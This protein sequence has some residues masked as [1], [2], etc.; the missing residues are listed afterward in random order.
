M[1]AAAGSRGYCI[2]CNKIFSREENHKCSQK[3]SKGFQ[4]PACDTEHAKQNCGFC[5]REFFGNICYKNHQ[6]PNS[7]DKKLSVSQG[8]RVFTICNKT[9]RVKEGKHE[10]GKTFCKIC[11]ES[12][13]TSHFCYV[14]P[15]IE[16]S[17]NSKS[18]FFLCF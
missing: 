1:V 16:P 10:C 2:T 3:C 13:P 8:I 7:F 17:K 9:V 11:K 14:Q 15:P 5:S 12:L 6:K 4:K 18:F